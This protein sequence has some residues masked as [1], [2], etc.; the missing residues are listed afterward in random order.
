MFGTKGVPGFRKSGNTKIS[1]TP[2]FIPL[3]INYNYAKKHVFPQTGKT[4]FSLNVDT[5]SITQ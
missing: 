5:K 3:V 1:D 2:F 4:C